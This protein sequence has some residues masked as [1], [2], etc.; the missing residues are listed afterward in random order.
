[1]SAM[2]PTGIDLEDVQG[3]ILRGYGARFPLA[4]YRFYAASTRQALQGFLRALMDDVTSAVPWTRDSVPQS[5]VNVALTYAGFAAL[6]MP[7]ELLDRFPAWFRRPAGT[8]AGLLGDTGASAPESWEGP[9]GTGTAH[10]LVTSYG[11]TPAAIAQ[12]RERLSTEV[13]RSTGGVVEVHCDQAQQLPKMREHFGYSDG[14]SQPWIEPMSD[15][16]GGGS[17]PRRGG[18]ALQRDG[19]WRPLKAGEFLLGHL[20]ED[21]QV[22][23]APTPEL[24]RNGTYVVWRKLA[25]DVAR[26]RATLKAEAERVDLTEEQLAAKVMGR[27]RDGT[28][29]MLSPQDNGR[30]GARFEATYRSNDFH[31]LPDDP[32][33]HIC[34]LGA[35]VRRTNPRDAL[36]PRASTRYGSALSNRHRIIRRG[37]PYG[38]LLPEGAE[39]AAGSDESAGH[40]GLIFVCFQADIARQFETIQGQ[41]CV[42]GN[43][44]GLGS[45]AD[46]LLAEG[47]QKLTVQGIPPKFVAAGGPMVVTRGTEY[48]FAPGMAALRKLAAGR[49]GAAAV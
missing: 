2:N 37:M 49:F 46:W 48:L 40:R 29:L 3:N 5:T 30:R 19:S 11:Q 1:M 14:L 23:A 42:D 7:D 43:A 38:D 26:F 18:G 22:V 34:P 12:L 45:D 21:G 31:Y 17:Q 35:H 47:R 15:G 6:G 20:D 39:N 9:L 8:R 25:Q 10:L 13:D 33:G 32:A 27:W 36:N 44:F 41:W 28:A 4:D 24:V 16:S